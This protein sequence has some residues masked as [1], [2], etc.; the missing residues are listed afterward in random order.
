LHT[1]ARPEGIVSNHEA[2]PDHVSLQ[3]HVHPLRGGLRQRTFR[4][5]EILM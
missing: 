1:A 5:G 2:L 3:V 4:S